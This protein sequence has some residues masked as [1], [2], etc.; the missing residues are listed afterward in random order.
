M[1]SDDEFAVA[2][3]HYDIGEQGEMTHDPA[4]NVL[5]VRDPLER[6]AATQDRTLEAT[7]ELLAEAKKKMYAARLQR[8]IPFID[9]T[10]YTGWNAMCISAVLRAARVLEDGSEQQF[11]LLSLDRLLRDAYDSEDGLRHV[12]SY[13]DDGGRSGPAAVLEDYAYTSL[14][15]LDAYEASGDLGYF[16]RAEEIAG[17]MIAD[18]HDEEDGGFFDLDRISSQNAV[19]ALS[20]R[21]KPFRDS[22]TPAANPSAAIA[23]L[24]LHA[25]NGDERL[26]ELAK[27]TL[28]VFAAAAEQYGITAGTY[29]LAATWLAH[30]HVQIVV[31]GGA[32]EQIRFLLRPWRRSR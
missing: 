25:L 9:H 6:I 30:P 1:L 24:R 4:K 5:W 12:I 18:F 26:R 19:G 29:G 28:E 15:C 27:G 22:P 16:Q 13:A 14:A 17:R 23:L 3:A 8:P 32:R 11:A 10:L 2:V 7:S 31:I 21:R 20:T